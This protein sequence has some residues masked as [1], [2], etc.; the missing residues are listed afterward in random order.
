MSKFPFSV[1]AGRRSTP[2]ASFLRRS[3][4][5][6]PSILLSALIAVFG[7]SGAQAQTSA[8]TVTGTV[9]DATG[10]IL[11]GAKIEIRNTGTN[12]ARQ[13]TTDAAGLYTVNSLNPGIYKVTV[14]DP[15]FKN[16]VKSDINLVGGQRAEENARLEVGSTDQVVEVTADAVSLDTQTANREVTIESEAIESLP[17]SF[18]NPLYVTQSTAGVVSVRTGL[19]A[20]MTDQNQNRFALTG[21]RDESTAVLVDGASIV[22][23][24]LGGAMA[25]PAMDATAEVQVQRTA[26]DAAYT[27]TDGG[28]VS[29]ITKSGSNAFHGTAFEYVRN[30]HMDANSWDNK[31]AAIARPLYQR[32]QF[33]GSIGGPILR[34][35]LFFF[36]SYD[37]LRQADPQTFTGMVPTDLE[38]SGDF[39]ASGVTIY[40][41]FDVVNGARQPFANNN[42]SKYINAVG[43]AA[44]ALYPEANSTNSAFNFAKTGKETSNYDKVDFRGDYQISPKDTLFA[45]ITKAWQ[46]NDVPR[47]FKNAADSWDG[48]NDYRHVILINNTWTPT[49]RWVIN[50]VISYGKWTEEGT[51]ASFGH[52]PSELGFA[53][54]TT[55]QWQATNAYPEF[56]VDNYAQLG[57]NKYSKTPHESDTL[58]LNVSHEI[59]KHSLKAGFFGEIQRLYPD[60]LYSPDFSFTAS[61]T[62]GPTPGASGNG[63]GNSLASLLIGAGTSGSVQYLP[64]LDL[65]QLNFGWFLQDTWHVNDKLTVTAGLRHDIQNAR[66]ERFNRL[67]NFDPTV[68][69]TLNG[70]TLTGGLVFLNSKNRGLWDA[71]YNN[72]DPRVSLAYKLTPTLVV[73]A[74]YGLYNPPTFSYSSDATNTSDGYSST[75]TWNAQSGYI[76]ENLLSNPFPDGVVSPIGSS[77]GA[78]T[79]VGQS[80]DAMSRR[81]KTPYSQVY[82]LDFQY[83]IG[84]AGLFEIGYAGSQGRQLLFGSKANLNQLPASYL[85]LGT[86]ALN[87]SVS[88]PYY[89]IITDSTSD[90]SAATIPYWRTLVQ[91]PQFTSVNRLA[92]NNGASSSFNSLSMKYN[93]RF[94]FG[95]NIL[96]TYQWSKAIDN[97]SEN[98]GWEVSDAIRNIF[99]LKRDRSISAHDMPQSFASTISYDL[100]FGRGKLFGANS[101][102]IVNTIIGGWKIDSIIR[103]NSGL[104]IHLTESGSLTG[105]NYAVERPNVTGSLKLSNHKPSAWFNTS[106][107]SYASSGTSLAIGNAPRYIGNVRYM[108][109]HNADLDLQK[110]F[111]LYNKAK[112]QFRAE[113]YNITNTPV[114]G[115]PDTNLGD[116]AFGQVTYT[117]SIGPRTIQLGAR[118]DF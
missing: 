73:R 118:I 50:S 46:K 22:S 14:T 58:Q 83:Q 17:T 15:G 1:S 69:S 42:V 54:S 115:S 105:Y 93:Q 90:L 87:K 92:S 32:N 60:V 114:F 117:K 80:V 12:E 38:R 27:H 24:D 3:S 9:T 2:A 19:G 26:Y 25:T 41:P 56:D 51:S 5:F 97:T 96:A 106:A 53:S 88:N 61:M 72:F 11:S 110:S 37:A 63:T 101:G 59:G 89:G 79:F 35:K 75:T 20:Y 57:R 33:G 44:I 81:H 107:V 39:S 111:K 74:G 36:G 99:D 98:N 100:P 76:P 13:T 91:Y 82:S 45:R 95:L 108:V 6:V 64:Q 102:S 7:I 47:F 4:L 34:N 21:G 43:K 113:A 65:Q 66:T 67:N 62:S 18:R 78:L 109:T 68:T 49:D 71:S 85:S 104:P 116:S 48:E 55:S 86:E 94:R 23:P 84:A 77:D 10:A 31:N 103:F 8:A 70:K 28:A 40:N 29:M 30:D 16:F 112:M 52:D